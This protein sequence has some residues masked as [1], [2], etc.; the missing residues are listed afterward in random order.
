MQSKRWI[1]IGFLVLLSGVAALYGAGLSYHRFITPI[2][3]LGEFYR[4]HGDS[5]IEDGARMEFRNLAAH[6]NRLVLV[7]NSWHPPG[8]PP[9]HFRVRV[10]GKLATEFLAEP[11]GTQRIRLSGDCQ[12]RVASFEV[13]N[14]FQPS[15]TDGRKLGAQ[16]ISARVTSK[17][18]V[19]I[20]RQTLLLQ[21]AAAVA[22]LALLVYFVVNQFNLG[23]LA[24]TVPPLAALMLSRAKYLN[25]QKSYVFWLFAVA[26]AGGVYVASKLSS[27]S[28]R[29]EA[30]GISPLEQQ[31]STS[32]WILPLV[33]LIVG[34]GACLRFYGLDF[35]LP[36]NHHPDEVPKF[37]AIMRMVDHGDLN[38]R[39]FL[40]PSLLLYSTYFMNNF[41]HAL[42]LLSGPWQDTLVFAGRTASALAGTLSVYFVYVIG[43]RLYSPFVGIV[44]SALLAVFPLHVTCS[45]YVKEDAL[46]V[47]FTLA[48]IVALLKAVQENRKSFLLLAGLLAG[49]SASVKYSGLL[50]VAVVIAAPW[51]RSKRLKPDWG[52]AGWTTFALILIPVG[53]VL[54]SPYT[55][56]DYPTFLKDFQHEQNHMSRGHTITISAW[57]QF[58]MYHF[59]RSII[60]GVSWVSALLAVA[61]IGLLLWRQKIE[62]LYLVA[63]ILLFYVPAEWVKAKPAP[64]PER[65]ILPCLPFIAIAASEFMRV[66]L[67]SRLRA[68]VPLLLVLLVVAPA[69]RTINLTAEVADDTRGRLAAWMI[70]NIPHGSSVF[71][72]WKPYVPRFPHGEFRVEYLPRARIIPSLDLGHLR[73]SGKDYLILSSLFYSRYFTQPET[74]P[75]LREQ[76]RQVFRRVPIVKEI[77]PKHGTYGFHNPTVTL[78]SLKEEDFHKLEAELALKAKGE[79]DKTSNEMRASFRW[80][81]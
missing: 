24:Y 37:N 69:L 21:I 58:W 75:A 26:L 81:G 48:S 29:A 51:L 63:L 72:D 47:F 54:C 52:Y 71:V 16:L 7:F 6:G 78:F 9:A 49:A 68:A 67:R 53:F 18:G 8:L 56:L 43:R 66:L 13:V 4:I 31:E 65:Y 32:P 14:P 35:G 77:R 42:G 34:V 62:D 50:S 10:C 70:E 5:W 33:L 44:S 61:G 76:I 23:L 20:L 27:R 57:S 45:R 46:L 2:S 38:P 59:S 39:Y 40:H 55:V 30:D 28:L 80:G 19:P 15:A 12:P 73:A 36:E 74:N 11:G 25:L 41:L 1:T 17:L 79:I 64:Q 3:S 60:P 22:L